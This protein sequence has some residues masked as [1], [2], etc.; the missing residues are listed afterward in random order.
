MGQSGYSF[1]PIFAMHDASVQLLAL[2]P[3]AHFLVGRRAYVLVNNRAE[4][5]APL[6][7][8]GLV[9]MLRG[10]SESVEYPNNE[11]F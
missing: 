8:E 5:N 6:T 4:G 1:P 3:F 9:G 11:Q 10:G 7:I 2:S